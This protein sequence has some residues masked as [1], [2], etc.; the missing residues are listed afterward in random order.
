VP[1]ALARHYAGGWSAREKKK[2]TAADQLHSRNY[3]I[4]KLANP[5]QG[6]TRNF[7]EALHLFLVMLKGCLFSK[8]KRV[9]LHLR[10]FIGILKDLPPIYNKWKRDR[11]GKHLSPLREGMSC[12]KVRVIPG[13]EQ[14]IFSGNILHRGN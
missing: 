5:F 8:P 6:I 4:Y 3:Y 10:V 11:A 12:K 7:G 13:K 9:G 14:D 2:I 1:S